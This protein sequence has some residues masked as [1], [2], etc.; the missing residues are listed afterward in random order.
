[1]AFTLSIARGAHVSATI[2][3]YEAVSLSGGAGPRLVD[4][5]IDVGVVSQALISLASSHDTLW[6]TSDD[7]GRID[8]G[9]LAPGHYVMSVVGGDLP[10]FT[11]FERKHIDIDVVAGEEREVELRVLP[12]Q[13][14]VQFI[15]SETVLV[16]APAKPPI[17]PKN[18]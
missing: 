13:R 10:E 8:F 7:R 9:S 1:V 2:H 4:S 5:L 17:K 16:A 15:G 14:A 18:P 6:Q 3:R 12:Q 11:A